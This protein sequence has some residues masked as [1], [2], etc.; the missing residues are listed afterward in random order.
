MKDELKDFLDW[1]QDNIED[2]FEIIDVPE[3]VIDRY[4]KSKEE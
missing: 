1:I 2:I 3:E 4:L